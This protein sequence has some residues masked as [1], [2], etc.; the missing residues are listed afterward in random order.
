MKD[1]ALLMAAGVLALALAAGFPVFAET[2]GD[3]EYEV[4]DA[5][6]SRSVTI[7]RYT[8]GAV[9]VTVPSRINGLP[10][11]TIGNSAFSDNIVRKGDIYHLTNIT[12]P[13]SLTTIGDAAFRGCI[14]LTSITFPASLTTIGIAAFDRCTSL[15][16]ITL[17]ESLTT[18]GDGMFRGCTSLTSI[19]VDRGNT[20]F[21]AVDGVLLSK[22][23]TTLIAYPAGKKGAYTVPPSVTKIERTA[24]SWCT[25]LTGITL[26]ASL[27]TIG[28][29]AFYECTG[30]TSI[31]L[32]ASLTA[33]GNSA[34]QG[35]TG[36]TSI[37]LPASLTSIGYSAFEGC[38]RL[39]NFTVDRG[40]IKYTAINGVLLSK[41]Q[42]TLIA[43]PAGKKGACTVPLTVTKIESRAFSGC[44]GLTSITLPA[45]LTIIEYDMFRGCTGLISITLPASLTAIGYAAFHGCTG[46]TSITLPASLTTIGNFAFDR[47]TGLTSITLP[48][49]L[50]TIGDAAFYE[51]TGLT[52]IALPASLTA[53][54]NFAFHGCTG[55]TSIALPASL[56]AIGNFAF[57]GCTGLTSIAL[58]AS[59]TTIGDAAFHGCTGL[60]NF[61]VD[62]GNI[63]YT[64]ING[65]LLSKDQTTLIAYPAGKKGAYTVPLLVTKIG[66]RAFS[67]CTGLTSIA[68]PAS[69]T[70]IGDT[71]FYGCTGL[72]SI[73]LP[74]S[75]TTIGNWAFDRCT[76]L[77]SITL[78][79][80]LT[81]IGNTAFY[82]CT[83]L[84]SVAIPAQ[85]EDIGTGAFTICASLT[86]FTVDD[87]N[88]AFTAID[89]VL[90]NKDQTI[91]VAYPGGKRG[92]YTLPA[93]IG[94][95]QRHAFVGCNGLTAI[96]AAGGNPA[97]TAIDG[98][99][100]SG[101]QTVLIAYPG[102][103]QGAYTIPPQVRLIG[104][105][106]FFHCS[107]LTSVT[108]PAGVTTIGDSAFSG[109]EGLTSVTLPA[110]LALDSARFP[111]GLAAVY[112]NGGKQAGTYTY[113]GTAWSYTGR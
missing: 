27:T 84:T 3:F 10:V 42:T 99:L 94:W 97:Y 86:G 65:V 41:D 14:G 78:P 47:C 17:P 57:Q 2:F 96:A 30:L 38:T 71:A 89:G 40:N 70:T 4:H 108:I 49:S 90:F 20:A 85:V 113:T 67:R 51:C 58:P 44:T 61:T 1:K 112:N 105:T 32:P 83:G 35:C 72:T 26:P 43:Y 107:G 52:S 8:G 100:F 37:T 7:T 19:T 6:G 56:T 95:I 62:R 69:L 11:T 82:E 45:S 75:L 9:H 104:R 46:L 34:F 80:S 63:K 23:Q 81:T 109:C 18:I 12:L 101:D 111:G 106:A 25:G 92:A 54:G 48:A 13:A 76:G 64:A 102:G 22:D 21:T 74:E 31:A 98:V 24:L 93:Q 29:A 59:L 77:T 28:D 103:K 33:I 16:S 50:T 87:K 53:I 66:G 88:T 55:L 110:N 79:A 15:T 68:L 5:G 60:T 73:T 39:T 91:L 36:L